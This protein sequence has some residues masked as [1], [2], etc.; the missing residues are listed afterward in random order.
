[1]Q[2]DDRRILFVL[3]V[4]NQRLY[5]ECI[6]D[7]GTLAI[8]DEYTVENFSIFDAKSMAEGYN[9]AL[10]HPA[11]YKIYIH[12]DTFMLNKNILS[13]II[14][15]FEAHPELGLIGMIG[16][17]TL[18]ESGV[19]WEGEGLFG[20]LLDEREFNRAVYQFGEV[21]SSYEEVESVDG[22]FIATQYDIPWRE[23]ME[24]FHFYDAS[25]S[26][27]FIKHGYKVGIPRQEQPWT[28]HINK[29]RTDSYDIHNHQK[30]QQLFLQHYAERFPIKM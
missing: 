16:C 27:E 30:G 23:E 11:K 2:M 24:G 14:A 13:D 22:F 15:L 26:L 21:H 18:S 29:E 10:G 8:P 7:L 3:C 20:K 5:K 12:Q 28:A 1:M 9:R 19:W 6:N 17:K 4:S 25:Q